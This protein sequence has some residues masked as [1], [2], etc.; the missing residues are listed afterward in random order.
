M[1][2]L[3]GGVRISP[4]VLI[5]AILLILCLIAVAAR[6]WRQHDQAEPSPPLHSTQQSSPLVHYLSPYLSMA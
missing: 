5:L 4:A 1:A 3:P 6:I 2:I